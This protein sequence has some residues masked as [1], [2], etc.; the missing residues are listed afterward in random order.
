METV[1]NINSLYRLAKKSRKNKSI[2]EFKEKIRQLEKFVFKEDYTYKKIIK[3][4]F[5]ISFIGLLIITIIFCYS[6]FHTHLDIFSMTTKEMIEFGLFYISVSLIF[7]V[8][9]FIMNFDYINDVP[10]NESCL[11]KAKEILPELFQ[12]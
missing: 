8:V 9:A 3:R 10:F 7:M 11:N 6:I 5:R 1:K 2:I 12:E 4:F